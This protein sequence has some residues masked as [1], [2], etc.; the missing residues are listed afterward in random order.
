MT[1]KIKF[2]EKENERGKKEKCKSGE[3]RKRN[4]EC[5]VA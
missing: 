1:V 2:V 3:T 4:K 5:E